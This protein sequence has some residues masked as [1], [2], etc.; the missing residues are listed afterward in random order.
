MTSTVL[1]PID[2]SP[3]SLR[4]LC[5]VFDAF[6]DAKIAVYHVVDLFAPGPDPGYGADSSLEIPATYEP[7]I[8]TDEWYGTVEESTD[9]LF[10][11]GG[12]VA[13]EYDREVTTES[14]IS[15]PA[16]L[17]VEYGTE[18]A[19]DHVVLGAHG[20]PDERRPLYGSVSETVVPRV[21]VPVP[22]T[23]VR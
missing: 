18:E 13:A 22:V 5:H 3:L 21:P 12:E 19:V 20:R 2:G 16:R 17:I 15:N 14:D 23:A 4:P 10:E 7:M 9:R 1:V 8:G 11:E 6:P